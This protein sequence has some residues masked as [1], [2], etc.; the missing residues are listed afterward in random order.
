[1]TRFT[2]LPD[3]S[4]ACR[5]VADRFVERG[6]D[7]TEHDALAVFSCEH[8]EHGADRRAQTPSLSTIRQASSCPTRPM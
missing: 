1:M 2:V 6:F 7:I 3:S 5:E 8:R 4:S